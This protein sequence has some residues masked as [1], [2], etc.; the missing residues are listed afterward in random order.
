MIHK[1][2][3]KTIMYA[4]RNKYVKQDR[5]EEYVYALEIVLNILIADITMLIIGLAMHMVWECIT[6]WLVYKAL[7]KYCG[8]Y[9]FA[10]SLKCYLSS[11]LMCPIVL[12][13]IKYTPYN[14]L[15]YGVITLTALIILFI[16]SPVEAVN[17]PLDE[18][19]ERVFGIVAKILIVLAAV[20]WGIT[21]I[22]FHKTV[23]SHIISLSVISVAVFV[24]AGKIC[25]V[26]Q[27]NK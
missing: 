23:L 7:R 19:E 14:V 20:C 9:H 26:S 2:S 22:V 18:K 10:T 6:F 3:E 27:K 21:T 8:G 12:A 13:V 17:K 25:V 4:I 24:I 1:I 11:C 15:G 16:L 5:L